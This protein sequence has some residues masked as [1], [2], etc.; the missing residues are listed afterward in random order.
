MNLDVVVVDGTC[1][2]GGGGAGGGNNNGNRLTGNTVPIGEAKS[3]FPP[4]I[5]PSSMLPKDLARLQELF[6]E[7]P[8]S[9]LQAELHVTGNLHF[10]SDTLATGQVHVEVLQIDLVP[11]ALR[12]YLIKSD[13]NGKNFNRRFFIIRQLTGS[14][15]YARA[16][17]D[18]ANPLGVIYLFK[19]R[20]SPASTNSDVR[21]KFPSV[22]PESGFNLITPHRTYQLFAENQAEASAW[23]AVLMQMQML[24]V[25]EEFQTGDEEV[26]SE[27]FE[28]ERYSMVSGWGAYF[29]PGDR[30][31]YSDRKG[32][33]SSS[34]FPDVHLPH[35]YQWISDW[36][37]DKTYTDTD[38]DGWTFGSTF[39]SIET[40]F[41]HGTSNPTNRTFDMCRRRRW[42]RT[43][44]RN[45]A[46]STA[47]VDSHLVNF[48]GASVDGG[49]ARQ[50]QPGVA[51][52]NLTIHDHEAFGLQDQHTDEGL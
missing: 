22:N 11:V 6:P 7:V 35:G 32:E 12:G 27:V 34:E 39:G 8:T 20:L 5:F 23:R 42:V 51:L 9:M 43:S 2:R 29:M 45:V 52:K 10:S 16:P 50:S 40:D 47:N 18:M 38:P 1:R 28:N 21:N 13:P 48:G 33:L 30:S 26:E 25:P 41:E 36:K 44:R 17:E 49:G 19:S 31:T 46:K 37:V 14:L 4:E 15:C 24:M 3:R